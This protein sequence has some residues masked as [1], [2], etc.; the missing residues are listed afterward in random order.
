MESHRT[1]GL[2]VS[3][4]QSLRTS[5]QSICRTTMLAA[6]A[7]LAAA[8]VAQ[9][10][11]VTT[12]YNFADNGISGANPW[13]VTLV[14]GTNGNLY[15]TTYNGG[16]NLQGTVFNVTTSGQLK[17]I[18]NFGATTTDGA[19]PTGGLTLGTDGNFYGTTMQGGTQSMGII[20]KITPT[21]TLTIL[22]NFNTFKDGAFPWGP[23]ILASDGNFY[24]TTSGGG[25]NSR[26]IVY[27][28]TSS[29]TFTEIYKFDVTLL[30]GYSPIAP[31]TQGTDGFLYIPVSQGGT[32]FCGTILKLSTSGVVNN[33]YSFP[34]GPGGYFPIGPLV[35]A[36]N[37]NFYSTTQNGGTNNEGTIYQVTP[38]LA[39]TVLHSFGATFG[40]GTLPAA[41]LLL[42]TDGNYYSATSDGGSSGDG[43]LFNTSTSGTYSSLYSF[44]NTVNLTQTSPLSPPIQATNGLLYGMTEFGGP[45][46]NGTIYSLDMGLAPFVNTA[47][48]TGKQG[49]T[50]TLLGAHLKGTTS[51]TFNG[52]AASFKVLSDTHLTAA[53]PPGATSGPIQVITPG[54]ALLS[55]KT[56]VV[57][58]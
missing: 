19:F 10:Q 32:S 24:G 12:I 38:G 27:K 23:P 21:G 43:T 55:R 53:V 1:A 29:G 49:S 34:C 39:V 31:P 3:R 44:N 47:L 42:A 50:V 37:G 15:G 58:H 17:I 13:Y 8:A 26:G 35:Q 45:T 30:H 20:F 16:A 6:A 41:G 56:F 22:H 14:Q 5:F 25:A 46:N 33:T 36:S 2:I 51:V 18:H 4:Q 28:I 40:D 57:K 52:I 7:L 9:A 11:T 48:F 54:G